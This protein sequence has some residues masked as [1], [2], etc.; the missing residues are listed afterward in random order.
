MLSHFLSLILALALIPHAA[1]LYVQ[2]PLAS[3]FPPVAHVGQPYSWTFSSKTFDSSSETTLPGYTVSSLPDWASFNANT[4][5]LSGTP[6][7]TDQGEPEITV[8]AYIGERSVSTKCNIL[9]TSESAITL[10]DSILSQFYKDNPSLSSVFL[11]A[12]NSAL[13]TEIPTLRVPHSWSFSIGLSTETFLNDQDDV[14]YAVLQSDKSSVPYAMKFSQGPNTLGGNAPNLEESG[15]SAIFNFELLGLVSDTYTDGVQPFNLAVADH[16]L[17][18]A[19]LNPLPMFNVSKNASFSFKLSSADLIGILV[20]NEPIDSSYISNIAID[21]SSYSWL[22]WDSVHQL[23]SGSTEG[24]NFNSS[25]GPQLSI[26]LTTTFDQSIQTTLSL[27]LEP[28]FFTEEILPV[29]SIPENRS[30][31]VD[32]RPYLSTGEQPTNMSIAVQPSSATP[33]LNFSSASMTLYGTIAKDCQAS[34]INVTIAAYSNVTHSTSH[35]I[36]PM[37][38]LYVDSGSG[39]PHRP[40]SLS[41]ADH[42]KLVLGLIIAFAIIGGM[43]V[44][45]TFLASVRRCLRVEDPALDTEKCQRNLSESDKRWYGLVDEKAGYGWS[46]SPTEKR[47][48]GMDLLRSPRNYGNIG[49]GLDPLTRSHTKDFI[50]SSSVTSNVQSP[51]R[52]M[53]KGDFMTRIRE[54]VRNVSDKF[55]SQSNRKSAPIKRG[56]IGKPILLNAHEGSVSPKFDPFATPSEGNASTPASVHFADLTRQLSNDSD[57]SI[58]THANEAIVQTATRHSSIPESRPRLKTVTSAMRV[59]IPKLVTSSPETDGST[60]G[61][62]LN[63]RVTSQKAK[64]WKGFEDDAIPSA[65]GDE[66]S[67]GIRY[68]TA[69]GGD[70]RLMVDSVSS[71]DANARPGSSYTISTHLQSTYSL[72]TPDYDGGGDGSRTIVRTDE[73]FEVFIP[74]G[75][76]KKVEAKLISGDDTPDWMIFDLRPKNGKVELYGLASLAD[77]GDWDVRILD[78]KNG[79][80]VGEVGLQ[81]VPRS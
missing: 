6:S 30:V 62:I 22:K 53:K 36:L 78:K 19:C 34:N 64:I 48:P 43:C 56:I 80:I 39:R 26:T 27:A 52:V 23:L 20:D 45:A 16:E 77:V 44:L 24:Q 12:P 75:E 73:R 3:Q 37:T 55:D 7:N 28:S 70:S 67:M 65:S 29:Y 21:T 41:I 33:C 40:G 57:G 2:I 50:P 42:K 31:S 81:V 9:V 4:R 76:A 58:R 60:S 14:H 8:T 15:P 35:A 49:L 17:S 72:E 18:L 51:A 13:S 63:A 59:P 66:L 68:V 61:S 79:N 25:T 11:L 54:T 74:V 10:H 38:D 32:I 46:T 5:T 71:V 69:L 1:S 47:R